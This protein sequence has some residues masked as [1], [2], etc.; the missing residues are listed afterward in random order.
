MSVRGF[1]SDVGWFIGVDS[2]VVPALQTGNARERSCRKSRGDG[3]CVELR[4]GIS[5]L[6]DWSFRLYGAQSWAR[7]SVVA[8]KPVTSALRY[9]A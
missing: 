7:M 5:G 1:V 9:W 6:N 4:T 2:S 8:T 3:T